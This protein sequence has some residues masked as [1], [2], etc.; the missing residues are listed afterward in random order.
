VSAPV[1]VILCMGDTLT[2]LPDVSAVN[3]L[4]A[5]VAQ[6]LRPGGRF[7]ASFRDYSVALH[8]TERFIPVR[9]DAER[10]LTCFLE[11]SAERVTVH[12][13]LHERSGASWRL[14]VSAYQK[15]R[16]SP[17]W[18]VEALGGLGLAVRLEPGLGGMVRVVATALKS[19]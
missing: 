1:E 2:H 19:P 12:D 3:A 10:I 8:A 7:V 16:L 5:L 9:S 4:F 18:V 11:Y 6:S 17:A 14:R 13:V 15:L